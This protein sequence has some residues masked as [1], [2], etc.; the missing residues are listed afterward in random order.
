MLL[1]VLVLLPVASSLGL[2]WSQED[3]TKHPGT[4]VLEFLEPIPPTLDKD[5]FMKRLEAAVED[6][7]AELIAEARGA[8]IV[9]AVLGMPKDELRRQAADAKQA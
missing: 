7:T 9:P 5:E 6:R 3:W 1:G 2:F 4:A 8:P